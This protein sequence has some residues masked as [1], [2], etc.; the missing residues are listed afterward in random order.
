MNYSELDDGQLVMLLQDGNEEAFAALYNRYWKRIYT[1]AFPYLK[2]QEAAQ[3][4]TQDVFVKLWTHKEHLA[5]VQAFRPYLFVMA[6]NM[7]IS[8]L[9][10]KV[11]HEYLDGDGPLEEELLLPERQLSFKQSLA[12]LHQAIEQL[13]PQQ[14][15]AYKLSRDEGM[16]YEQIAQEMDISRLTVRTHISK[17]NQFIRKFL[18]DNAV[19]SA[20]LLIMLFCK[21]S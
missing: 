14:Q 8:S 6:R 4:V 11:F 19:H 9:R 16:S 5:E 15:K 20:V 12:L 1:I 17:A 10:N 2:S 3:D 21:L 13:P 18:T 7:I